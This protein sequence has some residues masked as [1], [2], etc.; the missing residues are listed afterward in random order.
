MFE[1][2]VEER[3]APAVSKV[4]DHFGLIPDCI[5]VAGSGISQAIPEE[6]IINR[7]NYTNIPGF[8]V[9]A[10]KGHHSELLLTDIEGKKVFIYSGRFH[11]YEGWSIDE[12]CAP[13]IL[14][15]LAGVNS[16]VLT[17]AAGGLKPG[18]RVGSLLLLNDIIDFTSKTINPILN[19]EYLAANRLHRQMFDSEWKQRI[20]HELE[21][22]ST[23]YLEG[24]YASVPGPNYETRAEIR[25]LRKLQA[26]AVGMST[27]HEAKLAAILGKKVIASSLITNEAKEIAIDAVSHEEVLATANLAIPNIKKFI[28]S[29]VKTCG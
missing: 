11:P 5:I 17:N 13:V 26:D 14:G 19:K 16:F 10:V 8:P 27:V 15:V 7:I 9:S 20:K 28:D 24:I 22:C 6:V 25:M 18:I 1:K 12:I 4:L 21:S 23:P 29:A 3:Y 2:Y